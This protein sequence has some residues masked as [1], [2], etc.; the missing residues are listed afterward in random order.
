MLPEWPRYSVRKRRRWWWDPQRRSF[1]VR[2]SAGSSS[3]A[4]RQ[5]RPERRSLS[6]SPRCSKGPALSWSTRRGR[7][8]LVPLG[9]RRGRR[10][11]RLNRSPGQTSVSHPEHLGKQVGP[12]FLPVDFLGDAVYGR[13]S[14]KPFCAEESVQTHNE[15]ILC[16]RL[17]S[18]AQ[19][20]ESKARGGMAIL[21]RRSAMAAYTVCYSV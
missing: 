21:Y 7:T 18:V 3:E 14:K 5:C 16:R 12:C 9:G 2:A 20:K 4:G 19:A 10:T 11:A 8:F 17:W 6:L 13:L 15:Q 1:L